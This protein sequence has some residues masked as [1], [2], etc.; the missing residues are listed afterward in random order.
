MKFERTKRH[1]SRSEDC[2]AK[3][4]SPVSEA[5]VRRALKYKPTVCILTDNDESYLQVGR[6]GFCCCLE[7]HDTKTRRHLRGFQQPPVVPWPG[8]S[9]IMLLAGPLS[10]MQEEYFSPQQATDALVA[11]LRH[12]PWPPYIQWRDITAEL[13]AKGC[14]LFEGA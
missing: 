4:I 8:I 1:H 7:W 3:P 11:F 6:S 12:E 10:L 14:S 2:F 5:Q 13:N 9:K